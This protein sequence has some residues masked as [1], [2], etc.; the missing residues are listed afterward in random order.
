MLTTF[1][2]VLMGAET[3]TLCSA[4]YGQPSPDRS[5]LAR[6]VWSSKSAYAS[7]IASAASVAVAPTLST[8]TDVASF[9]QV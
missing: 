4:A 5:G 6:R 3:A 7:W 2:D 9:G 8:T 1:I